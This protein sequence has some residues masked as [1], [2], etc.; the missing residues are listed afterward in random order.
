MRISKEGR[1]V[2]PVALIVCAL[3]ASGLILLT[4]WILVFE[5]AALV[6]GAGIVWFF[7]VPQRPLLEDQQAIFAPCDGKVVIVKETVETEVT[8]ERRVQISIF[9]SITNIHQNWFPVGGTVTHFKH[10]NG[11]YHVAWHPKASEKNEHTTIAVSSPRGVI[12]FRQIAGIIA[13]RIVSYARLGA[14]VQQNTPCGFIKFGSRMDI[15]LP[16]DAELLISEG[17]CVRGSLTPIA[18]FV[19]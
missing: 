10:H 1:R 13:R 2:I 8:G 15:F 7:R 18:R 6:T 3:L 14:E 16:L 5:L 11:H 17:Q 9:M 12:V 19:K 4:G